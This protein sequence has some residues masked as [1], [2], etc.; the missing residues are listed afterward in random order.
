MTGKDYEISDRALDE[1]LAAL[2]REAA[3]GDGAWRAIEHRIRPRRR[4]PLAAAAVAMLTVGALVVG[5][6][7]IEPRDPSDMQRFVGAEVAA[8]QAS[9]PEELSLDRLGSP[10]ALMR[11]WTENRDAIAELEG[12]LARDP[13]KRLLLE[14]LA[15]ARLRQARLIN[16]GMAQS[17]PTR[18][19]L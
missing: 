4:V 5:R 7:G 2:T 9:A 11:A 6:W 8:M 14:F 10:E 16:A 1:R 12:A 18:T 13:E 19:S 3:P 15:E 17:H